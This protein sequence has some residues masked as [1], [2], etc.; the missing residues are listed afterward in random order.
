MIDTQND[1][2]VGS[3]SEF[4]N[5]SWKPGKIIEQALHSKSLADGS[6]L[7]VNLWNDWFQKHPG[8]EGFQIL[9]L[10]AKTTE[11][12]V[13]I[14]SQDD[15]RRTLGDL[16]EKATVRD[17][18]LFELGLFYG[19]LGP[20]RVFILEQ[21][22]VNS[23]AVR[24][25]GDINGI[26]RIRFR[27][28]KSF[29]VALN[30]VRTSIE[31]RSKTFFARWAPS[32]TLALGY[33][34]QALKP[35][36]KKRRDAG[37]GR[38]SF[39]V[40]VLVPHN[41]FDGTDFDHVRQVF[42]AANCVQVGPDGALAGR[43]ALWSFKCESGL[44]AKYFDIPTTL[45]TSKKVIES[46]MTTHATKSEVSRLVASQARAFSQQ[47]DEMCHIDFPE[48]KVKPFTDVGEIA[49]YLKKEKPRAIRKVK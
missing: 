24:I 45:L 39:E 22:S 47:I 29:I 5:L 28:K 43:P 42:E 36:I 48:I 3:S 8:M 44:S 11:W 10:A 21:E 16:I 14:F 7:S 35:F 9:D 19:H 23:S 40:E 27:D 26:Q 2:F 20:Q 34:E 33:I 41:S 31:L 25:A 15:L 46:Y 17:N 37:A 12:A 32:S 6:T 30:D 18:V 1:L 13:M 49:E 38:R 4:L